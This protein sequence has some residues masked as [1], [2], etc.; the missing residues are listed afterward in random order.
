MIKKQDPSVCCLQEIHFKYKIQIKRKWMEKIHNA[1][2]LTCKAGSAF[3][4]R[5][6]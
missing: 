5:S 6:E 1:N 2:M 4:N 3:K